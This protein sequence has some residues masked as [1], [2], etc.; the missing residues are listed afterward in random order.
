MMRKVLSVMLSVTFIVSLLAFTSCSIDFRNKI[1]KTM[2]KLLKAD[3]YTVT[4]SN[5]EGE[6]KYMVNDGTIYF[7]EDYDENEETSYLYG[8]ENGYYYALL[9]EENETQSVEKTK[10]EKDSYAVKY[11]EMIQESDIIN[12]VFSYR[13]ILDMAEKTSEGYKYSEQESTDEYTYRIIYTIEMDGS[14]LVLTKKYESKKERLE[15]EIRI[16]DIGKT[17]IEIPSEVLSK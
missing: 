11:M 1:E 8:D 15:E 12:Q 9:V 2:D 10:L 7:F 16:S 3:S 17:R 13:H 5:D 6:H 4:V 14:D